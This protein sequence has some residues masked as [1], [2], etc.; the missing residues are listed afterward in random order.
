[1]LEENYQERTH[2]E[3]TH[4]ARLALAMVG[5]DLTVNGDGAIIVFL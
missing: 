1:M 2:Q 4:Q 5:F 3:R